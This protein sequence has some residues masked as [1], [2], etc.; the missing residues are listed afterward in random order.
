[1]TGC[2]SGQPLVNFESDGLPYNV[3]VGN[4]MICISGLLLLSYCYCKIHYDMTFRLW[5]LEQV[6]CMFSAE[7]CTPTDITLEVM[8]AIYSQL[9]I[10]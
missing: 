4:I 3:A 1:M 8:Q 9:D 5:Q 7:W 2:S 10:H 6:L